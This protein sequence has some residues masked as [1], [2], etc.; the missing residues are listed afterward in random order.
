MRI[1]K[2]LG[3]MKMQT[4]YVGEG[5]KFSCQF[6]LPGLISLS[7]EW[8]GKIQKCNCISFNF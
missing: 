4:N 1:P 3:N 5:K 8:R 7:F 6:T 2:Q